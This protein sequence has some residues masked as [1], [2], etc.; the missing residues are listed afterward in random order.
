MR[1]VLGWGCLLAALTLVETNGAEAQRRFGFYRRTIIVNPVPGDPVA[2]GRRLLLGMSLVSSPTSSDPWL[3]KIEPGVYDLEDASL[4]MQPF[5]DVEGSG[6]DRTTITGFPT[7]AAL[8]IGAADSELRELSVEH[9]GGASGAT[10]IRNEGDRFSMRHVSASVRDA[11][12]PSAIVNQGNQVELEFVVGRAESTGH[13]TAILN[14]GDGVHWSHIGA[15]VAG[16]GILYALFNYGEGAFDDVVAEAEGGTFA[17]GIRNEG[18][19]ASPTMRGLRVYAKS[20]DVAQG[21]TNGAGSSGRL[22]DV[23]VRAVGGVAVGIKNEF[24]S[25][26]IYDAEVV[27]EGGEFGGIGVL[28]IFDGEPTLTDVTATATGA[29]QAAGLQSEAGVKTTVHRSTLSSNWFSIDLRF[30][31]G[32]ETYVGAS[33]L[34]GPVRVPAGAV[35]KCVASYD[36]SFDPLD[37]ACLP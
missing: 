31:P 20:E 10:A 37:P 21:I 15:Y 29:T 30:D 5:A 24:G 28:N 6:S 26:S 11:D 25:P 33:Q 2:S 34:V 1:K 8:V 36:G 14:A 3:L 19:G 13:A 7:A 16:G 27:A 35:L 9:R 32:A 17:G 22:Y 18:Q 4:V 12:N 23:A